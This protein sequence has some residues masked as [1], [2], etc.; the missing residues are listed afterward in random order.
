[1][2]S[3]RDNPEALSFVSFK[4][5]IPLMFYVPGQTSAMERISY[6]K[7]P[8]HVGGPVEARM[9]GWHQ[10]QFPCLTAPGDSIESFSWHVLRNLH[11][12]VCGS[13]ECSCRRRKASVWSMHV[14]KN[15]DD[16]TT[17]HVGFSRLAGTIVEKIART[18]PRS[19][20]YESCV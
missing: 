11:F 3:D 13:V 6:C 20:V 12:H 10:R 18:C 7:D 9:K 2:N 15:Y 8:K 1:M 16:R 17:Q 5:K 4:R 19:Q 14:R